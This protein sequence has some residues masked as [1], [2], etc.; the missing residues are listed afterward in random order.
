MLI[1]DY[2]F[3]VPLVLGLNG[4]RAALPNEAPV[5]E[6]KCTAEIRA[7]HK[8]RTALAE[9]ETDWDVKSIRVGCEREPRTRD[10]VG[11]FWL[12]HWLDQR[13]GAAI[14]EKV[15]AELEAEAA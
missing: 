4:F 9:A 10:H 1:F 12:K 15:S 14:W 3:S 8:P 7:F 11:F 13:H 2:P 6:V 5:A